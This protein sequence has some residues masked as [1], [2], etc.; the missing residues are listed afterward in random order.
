MEIRRIVPKEVLE[1]FYIHDCTIVE[2]IQLSVPD[3]WDIVKDN[4]KYI[5][6][7][8]PE[9]CKQKNTE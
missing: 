5:K 4:H 6:I 7:I 9:E 1:R 8:I 3:R 2:L